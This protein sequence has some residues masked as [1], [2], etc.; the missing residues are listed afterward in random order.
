MCVSVAGAERA[1]ETGQG[2]GGETGGGA[3]S[4]GPCSAITSQKK[5]S[6]EQRPYE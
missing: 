6:Q 5:G 1:G 3:N 2:D 4:T